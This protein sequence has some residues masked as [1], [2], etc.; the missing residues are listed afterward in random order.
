M[1]PTRLL[2]RR[3][4]EEKAAA[5]MLR[6]GT[7]PTVSHERV[8]EAR[9]GCVVCMDAKATLT[10]QV[11]PK[12]ASSANLHHTLGRMTSNRAQ[13][14]LCRQSVRK[15]RGERTDGILVELEEKPQC[16]LCGRT[17]A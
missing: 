3:P 17:A 10:Q 5:A 16:L 15:E 8:R 2:E 7:R 13:C 1:L 6:C 12:A 11:G 4:A 14:G 9:R